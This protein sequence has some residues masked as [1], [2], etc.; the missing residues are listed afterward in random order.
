MAR[1]PQRRLAVA[2]V[3]AA[4]CATGA[5]ASPAQAFNPLKPV[6]AVGGLV[7]GLVGK[8]CS[9]V[10]HGGQVLSAGKKLLTGHVGSAVKTIVGGTGSSVASKATFALGLAAIVSWVL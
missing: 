9:A 2:T 5:A 7:S 1:V 10:Q 4:A 3:V 6:C 8:A